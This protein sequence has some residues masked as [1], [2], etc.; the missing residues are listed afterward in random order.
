MQDT[1]AE[2]QINTNAFNLNN[3]SVDNL[4]D[5]AIT[6]GLKLIGAILI[7]I[8]GFWLAGKL[9]KLIGKSIDKTDMTISMRKFT[10]SLISI[11]FKI[12]VILVAM[13][14]VGFEVTAFVALLGGL[15]VGIGMALQGSLANLAGGILIL[16]FKPFKVGDYIESIDKSGTV[17]EISVLQTILLTPDMRT[18]ILPNG[19]VFNNPIINFSRF[20]V[21]RVEV[22][23]GIGYDDDFDKAKEVLMEVFKNEP[24]M[25]NDR[26]YIIEIQEFGDSSINLAMYGY[27]KTENYLKAGWNLNR[28]VKKALDENGFNIPYPQRDLHIINAN[29]KDALKA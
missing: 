21:R 1:Q 27:T 14:T 4:A 10:Q 5:L 8:V 19:S 23:V 13:S 24:L 2:S 29:L 20:G 3:L 22:K 11:A 26:D 17:E 28:S 18:V 9:S 15:A 16:L 25:L 7:I 12:L 6:Y